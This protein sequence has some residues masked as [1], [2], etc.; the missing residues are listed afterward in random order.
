MQIL[1]QMTVADSGI[2]V[3][4]DVVVVAAAAAEANAVVVEEVQVVEH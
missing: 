1:L 2:D 4:V 3:D